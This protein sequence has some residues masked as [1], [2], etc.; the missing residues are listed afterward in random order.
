MLRVQA[1]LAG[2]ASTPKPVEKMAERSGLADRTFKRRFREP[3]G[4]WPISYVLHLRIQ[5]AKRMLA[6]TPLSI[7]D[8]SA[9]HRLFKR[10]TRVSPG[11]YRRRME[12]RVPYG[13]AGS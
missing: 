5:Q 9:F 11:V 8:S 12:V 4:H 7:E 10:I 6:R 3:T 13:A 1:W 2:N